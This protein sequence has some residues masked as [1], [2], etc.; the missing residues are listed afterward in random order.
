MIESRKK[1]SGKY[2]N[3]PEAEKTSSKLQI[4]ET[5][6][7]STPVINHGPGM[8]WSGFYGPGAGKPYDPDSD[9]DMPDAIAAFFETNDIGKKKFTCTLKEVAEGANEREGA[10]IKTWTSAIPSEEWIAREY[11]PG[12]Y[13]L[14]FRWRGTNEEGKRCNMSDRTTIA[15]SDRFS[16]EHEAYLLEKQLK[17]NAKRKNSIVKH[18]LKNELDKT[19]FN[20]MDGEKN[21]PKQSALHYLEEIK[22]VAGLLGVQMGQQQKP[23]FDWVSM[24]PALLPSLPA[25]FNALSSKAQA[26]QQATMNMINMM[27]SNMQSQQSN[28]LE[29]LKA[30]SGPTNAH[31][32]WKEFKDMLGGVVDIKQMLQGDKVSIADRIFNTVESVL[33]QLVGLMQMS[34]QQRIANPQYHVAKAYMAMNPDFKALREDPELYKMTV[35]KLV[36]AWGKTQTAEILKTA[37]LPVPPE[38]NNPALESSPEEPPQEPQTME[39][40]ND[41][42]EPDP[43]N[44]PVESVAE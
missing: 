2:I 5:P 20:E 42:T 13:V 18:R 6:E 9:E 24:L 32:S 19:L 28:S 25:L 14:L 37:D 26:Q 22:Q 11:G 12:E 4:E 10:Y 3:P 16:D 30:I 17:L 41:T 15:I 38:L 43:E 36:T 34:A 8:D 27:M 31:D 7:D 33:P 35:N 39:N 44:E 29:L 40:N 23:G 1:V 21:D